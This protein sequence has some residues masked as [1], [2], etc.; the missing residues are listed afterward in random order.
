MLSCNIF[1]GGEGL[2]GGEQRG[3][4]ERSHCENVPVKNNAYL[5][6]FY[7]GNFSFFVIFSFICGGIDGTQFSCLLYIYI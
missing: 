4:V 3:W 1:F 5:F 6:L 2:G 7:K